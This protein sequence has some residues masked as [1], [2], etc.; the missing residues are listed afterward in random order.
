MVLLCALTSL[1]PASLAQSPLI[2][3]PVAL[4]LLCAPWHAREATARPAPTLLGALGAGVLMIAS[5]RLMLTSGLSAPVALSVPLLTF[6]VPAMVRRPPR[7]DAALYLL[8]A[9]GDPLCALVLPGPTRTSDPVVILESQAI[10]A[11]AIA[12]LSGW[13]LMRPGLPAFPAA[14]GAATGGAL[15]IAAIAWDR[16]PAAV[17]LSQALV[18]A[19]GSIDAWRRLSAHRRMPRVFVLAPAALLAVVLRAVFPGSHG[20]A[21][22]TVLSSALTV[23]RRYGLDATVV[24]SRWGGASH[25]F[26]ATSLGVFPFTPG[27]L[28]VFAAAP[29]AI[30]YSHGPRAA[31]RSCLLIGDIPA[32]ELDALMAADPA[33]GVASATPS[34]LP[35]N[36]PRI[37]RVTG[38]P[39]PPY[40]LILVNVTG[41]QVERMLPAL[42]DLLAPDGLLIAR[43]LGPPWEQ[44]EALTRLIASFPERQIFWDN[45]RSGLTLLSRTRVFYD[46]DRARLASAIVA[47]RFPALGAFGMIPTGAWLEPAPGIPDHRR[48]KAARMDLAEIHLACGAPH[49]ANV[50]LGPVEPDQPAW[51]VG[52]R[53]LIQAAMGDPTDDHLPELYAA[54]AVRMDPTNPFLRRI[55]VL[56][57]VPVPV[58]H[59][60]IEEPIELVQIGDEVP[61][62]ITVGPIPVAPGLPP[63][64]DYLEPGASEQGPAPGVG[65]AISIDAALSRNWA[66][67]THDGEEPG[68]AANELSLPGLPLASCSYAFTHLLVRGEAV[69][70]LHTPHTAI[71][72][73]DGASSIVRGDTELPLGAGEHRIL[74]KLFAPAHDDARLTAKLEGGSS[75]AVLR[76]RRGSAAGLVSDRF[77]A[78]PSCA[79]VRSAP[80]RR[81]VAVSLPPVA[82]AIRTLA[83]SARGG[84]L[85]HIDLQDPAQ[86]VDLGDPG[87]HLIFLEPGEAVASELSIETTI[88]GT[89]I[90]RSIAPRRSLPGRVFVVP[91]VPAGSCTASVDALR[92]SLTAVQESRSRAEGFRVAVAS[93]STIA[94]FL[95]TATAEDRTQIQAGM[96]REEIDAPALFRTSAGTVP[97]QLLLDDLDRARDVATELGA[98]S[99]VA[100]VEGPAELPPGLAQLIAAAGVDAVID[101]TPHGQRRGSRRED[102]WSRRGPATRRD[103][104]RRPDALWRALLAVDR[105]DRLAADGDVLA[106][107]SLAGAGSASQIAGKVSTWNATF[108]RPTLVIA[109]AHAAI[110]ALGKVA[111]EAGEAPGDDGPG[112]MALAA[113]PQALGRQRERE[114]RAAL[115]PIFARC[116]AGIDV[117]LDPPVDACSAASQT[118]RSSYEP[119]ALAIAG[120]LPP[121]A[122]GLLVL[123]PLPFERREVVFQGATAILAEAP[124][125][126]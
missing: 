75:T 25:G 104:L 109:T 51:Q 68:L 61:G 35:W 15:A 96:A 27:D 107:A 97:A 120:R 28:D 115:L 2:F 29:L 34:P 62:W 90:R 78:S 89:T 124:P 92:A 65:D 13:V 108:A 94:A 80:E 31:P 36:P 91:V 84:P 49:D 118:D 52:L 24:L 100:L 23:E 4:S 1:L 11:A 50:I 86:V 33:T 14:A 59:A 42:P 8:L 56:C 21:P 106:L 82:E 57:G 17:A 16:W 66:I 41:R 74:V 123:N 6:C 22:A 119:I 55:A 112:I 81:L 103:E 99:R 110:E 54:E 102:R 26:A 39:E 125:M 73:V 45:E 32:S 117:A 71:A 46:P 53:A 111:G 77:A 93:A 105:V 48:D 19:G 63:S 85:R 58:P 7:F 3:V 60:P 44:G 12:L 113:D 114:A 88:A 69:L 47:R 38:A 87:R 10:A 67:A 98:P 76:G 37:A 5:V 9:L 40:D 18:A 101:A 122:P 20:I 30:T 95:A 126:G 64:H 79:A 72:M 116:V 43:R 83:I 121:E 70:S